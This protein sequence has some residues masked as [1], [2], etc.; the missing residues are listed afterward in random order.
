MSEA[1]KKR[2]VALVSIEVD[3]NL[4]WACVCG[5]LSFV[6]LPIWVSWWSGWCSVLLWLACLLVAF[7]V[8]AW[9]DRRRRL[10][11]TGTKE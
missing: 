1:D 2:T 5:L 4:T 11:G 7:R 9:Q 8:W 6:L 10:L 3:E